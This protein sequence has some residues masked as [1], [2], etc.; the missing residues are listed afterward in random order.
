MRPAPPSTKASRSA[1][2]RGQDLDV[3][4]TLHAMTRLSGI[5]GSVPSP[6]VAAERDAILERLGVGSV[7]EVPL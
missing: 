5:E 3:A 6:D 7:A 2:S 4:L 1:R